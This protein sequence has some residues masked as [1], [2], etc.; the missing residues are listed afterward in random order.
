MGCLGGG[1]RDFQDISG[2]LGGSPE[3]LER[4]QGGVRSSLGS[5][6]MAP[7]GPKI[8]P[9]HLN[10]EPWRRFGVFGR[11]ISLELEI[12]DLAKT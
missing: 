4:L 2:V 10:W 11:K 1:F 8:F 3:A 12:V 9:R 5:L 6:G 7:N